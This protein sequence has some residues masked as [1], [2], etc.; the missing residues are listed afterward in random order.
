MENTFKKI[1][2]LKQQVPEHAE[3]LLIQRKQRV[4]TSNYFCKTFLP[5]FGFGFVCFLGFF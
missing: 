1:A 3:S 2:Q 4:A 5:Q